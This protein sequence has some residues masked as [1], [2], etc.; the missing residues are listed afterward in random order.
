M[1]AKGLSHLGFHDKPLDTHSRDGTAGDTRRRL[2]HHRDAD[3]RHRGREHRPSSIAVDL[4]AGMS[5]LQ[6]VVDAYT[7][8][9]ATVVLSAARGRTAVGAATSSSSVWWCSRWH[10]WRARS[11]PNIL[12]LDIA[13]AVQGWG[14]ACCSRCSLAL[15]ADV[16]SPGKDRAGALAAYGATI[17]GAFALG[18]LA[19]GMLTEWLDWRAIFLVNLPIGISHCRDGD[20]F[21]IARPE[22]PSPRHRRSDSSPQSRSRRWCSL[23][24]GAMD[25]GGPTPITAVSF[26]ISIMRRRFPRHRDRG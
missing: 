19:G 1:D 25:T 6:W 21:R 4:D 26:A 20:G 17:G 5:T 10:R 9:L 23:C 16:F 14:G 18:P 12:T 2:R 13:R 11:P 7:L 24:C 3:A 22:L 15:L 8:A